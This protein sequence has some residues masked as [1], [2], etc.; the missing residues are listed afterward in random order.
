MMR[1]L[2]VLLL[3]GS[4]LWSGYWFVGSS[5]VRQGAEQWFADQ[6]A[7]GLTAE[8]TALTVSGF[9]NRF[10]L[11]AEGVALKDPASGIGWQAPFAEV[12]A[13]TWKPW[14]IIAALPPEQTLSLPD[15]SIDIS[16]E[17]LRTS[18]RAKPN[19]DL[20]LANVAVETGP[21][22][23]RSTKGWSVSALRGFVSF[24]DGADAATEIEGLPAAATAANG[25]VLQIDL[26]GLV[27]DVPGFDRIAAEAGLP[28]T[29]ETAQLLAVATLT[30]PLDRNTPQTNPRLAGVELAQ[31]LVR[32]G[33][34][35]ATASGSFA[36]DD[37]GQAAGRIDISL[38]NWQPLVP[39]LV[40]AGAIKPE[41][42]DTVRNML[43]AL[44]KDGG[45]ENVVTLPLVMSDGVMSLGPL[46]LGPAPV[47]LPPS[48]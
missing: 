18:L 38:T 23:L 21:L 47:L 31:S 33:D 36:A 19:L 15:Q 43:A 14:H 10:D 30:A 28:T 7:K 32:W 4:G 37:S 13:M 11:R 12:F 5:F 25:Y 42:A 46:P 44:A 22:T 34:L 16:S 24:R 17:A 48:G 3:L 6:A 1:R 9:P 27:P 2:L 35:S 8:N 45:D 40:A 20:P 26:A 39:A 29:V 41:L